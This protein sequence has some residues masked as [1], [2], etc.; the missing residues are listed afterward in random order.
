MTLIE[1]PPTKVLRRLRARSSCFEM[2]FGAAICSHAKQNFGRTGVGTPRRDGQVRPR[3]QPFLRR[4]VAAPLRRSRSEERTRIR[5]LLLAS[6][7]HHT[8]PAA[9]LKSSSPADGP[10]KYVKTL[11]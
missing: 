9:R 10:S 11:T 7:G 6:S 1:P 8:S 3:E 4:R 2:R 5:S